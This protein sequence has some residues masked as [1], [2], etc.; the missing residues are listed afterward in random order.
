MLEY[1]TGNG[2]TSIEELNSKNLRVNRII[3]VSGMI[4]EETIA[5]YAVP[6][7]DVIS[8]GAL[9]HSVRNFDVSLEIEIPDVYLHRWALFSD[10]IYFRQ[11]QGGYQVIFGCFDDS[12]E[13]VVCSP[14][15]GTAASTFNNTALS[16]PHSETQ[17]GH[18]LHHF[19]HRG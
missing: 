6:G 10:Y 17:Q 3:E 13:L 4:T 16:S 14:V 5:G 15:P 19:H 18:R 1:D 9:T 8:I 12:G 2:C 7:V 11:F